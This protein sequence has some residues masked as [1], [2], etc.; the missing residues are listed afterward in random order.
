MAVVALA[1]LVPLDTT[2]RQLGN[3]FRGAL[4]IAQTKNAVMMDA[5]VHVAHALLERHARTITAWQLAFLTVQA[6]NVGTTVATG[7]V[8]NA[9]RVTHAMDSNAKSQQ[10]RMPRRQTRRM[11]RKQQ[12]FRLLETFHLLP[13]VT[14][15]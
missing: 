11:T 14:I 9:Q 15:R 8:V 13:V 5:E 2:V 4:A 6:R 10:V 7:L 3:A 12:T 1:E